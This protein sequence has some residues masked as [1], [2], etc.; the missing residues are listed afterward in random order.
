M[1]EVYC[2]FQGSLKMNSCP[3]C[4]HTKSVRQLAFQTTSDDDLCLIHT[5]DVIRYL[6]LIKNGLTICQRQIQRPQRTKRITHI[7]ENQD[8]C[9]DC[10]GELV[11]IQSQELFFDTGNVWRTTT[12]MKCSCG[13]E[14]SVEV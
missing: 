3:I 2:Q 7:V 13:W 8:K 6:D 10:D 5:L 9:P 4:N 12:W 1:Q 11:A 14:M